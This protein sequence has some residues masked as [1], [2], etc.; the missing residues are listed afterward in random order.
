MEE[1]HSPRLLRG[2][3][4]E[5]ASARTS[6]LRWFWEGRKKDVPEPQPLP[7]DYSVEFLKGLQTQSGKLEFECNS[8]KRLNDPERPPVVEYV[9]SW[10]GP[11]SG[12]LFRKYPL[13][14]LTPH[15]KYS[16][17]TQG[18]GKDSFLLNVPD[19]RVKVNDWYTGSAE[20]A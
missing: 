7:S 9:P 1:V 12:E 8:L 10:E 2:P 18:D 17:H 6:L 20:F 11:Q 15:S 16:F 5:G 14:L 4:G 13:Q 19:H 3:V